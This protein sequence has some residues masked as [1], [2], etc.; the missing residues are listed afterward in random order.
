LERLETQIPLEQLELKLV[1]ASA[2]QKEAGLRGMIEDLTYNTSRKAQP[3]THLEEIGVALMYSAHKTPQLKNLG[4]WT[5]VLFSPGSFT[6][7]QL[8]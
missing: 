5:M 1:V 3:L 7:S 2:R 8:A 4:V 6:E